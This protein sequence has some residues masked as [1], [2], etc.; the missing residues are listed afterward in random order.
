MHP[1]LMPTSCAAGVYRKVSNPTSGIGAGRRTPAGSY[2]G[3]LTPQTLT[4][5]ARDGKISFRVTV[6]CFRSVAAQSFARGSQGKIG[7]RCSSPLPF[8]GAYLQKTN[9]YVSAYDKRV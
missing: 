7:K 6:Y 1:G 8:E 3:K 2:F 9:T 5:A 4:Q